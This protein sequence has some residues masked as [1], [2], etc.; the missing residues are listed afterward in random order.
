[1]F[2]SSVLMAALIATTPVFA[3]GYKTILIFDANGNKLFDA[4]VPMDLT[5][6]DRWLA[7]TCKNIKVMEHLTRTTPEYQE[8]H[9]RRLEQQRIELEQIKVAAAAA[10]QAWEDNLRER[11]VNAAEMNAAAS[12]V[13]ARA[14]V[15]QAMKEPKRPIVNVNV[16]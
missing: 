2:K 15:I 5:C 10:R 16:W 13:S 6:E 3:D 11:E 7:S 1:M 9:Y 8:G 4:S 12:A 14:N